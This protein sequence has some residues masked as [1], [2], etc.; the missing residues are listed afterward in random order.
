MNYEVDCSIV[1]SHMSLDRIVKYLREHGINCDIIYS[2]IGDHKIILYDQLQP[3]S[4]E[5]E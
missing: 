3:E 2:E 1:S 4:N 5:Q